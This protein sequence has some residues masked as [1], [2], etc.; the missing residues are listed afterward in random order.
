MVY[1]FNLISRASIATITVLGDMS[2]APR[3][4]VLASYRMGLGVMAQSA[5]GTQQRASIYITNRSR[6]LK[7]Y[8]YFGESGLSQSRAVRCRG[9]ALPVACRRRLRRLPDS[10]HQSHGDQWLLPTRSVSQYARPSRGRFLPDAN[11]R[12]GTGSASRH[13]SFVCSAAALRLLRFQ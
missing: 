2:T 11:H 13:R 6:P 10:G 4:G 3:A 7:C 5:I 9:C 8:A 1:L 12:D